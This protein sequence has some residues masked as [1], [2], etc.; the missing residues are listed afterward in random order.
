MTDPLAQLPDVIAYATAQ[1]SPE[2]YA[3]RVA[4]CQT[5]NEHGTTLHV[6][7]D[8]S[9][10]LVWGGQPLARLHPLEPGNPPETPGGE[11]P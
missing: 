8:G 7:E 1:L 4:W 5:M 2:D 9:W 6:Q 10:L 11:T 3:S